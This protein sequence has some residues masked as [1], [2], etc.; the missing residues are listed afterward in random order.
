MK[1]NTEA[2]TK[3]GIKVARA[4]FEGSIHKKLS[5]CFVRLR[6]DKGNKQITDTSIIT[7]ILGHMEELYKDFKPLWIQ[8]VIYF[9]ATQ[10]TNKKFE[11]FW[12]WKTIT[13]PNCKLQDSLSSK[14]LDVL[15]LLC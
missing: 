9:K 5:S 1:Q 15:E 14:D 8:R 2:F 10:G 4:Y 6:D 13:K 12:A 11:D 7:T 3:Q